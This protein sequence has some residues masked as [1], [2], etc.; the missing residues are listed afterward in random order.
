MGAQPVIHGFVATIE[1]R[2]AVAPINRLSLVVS[3]FLYILLI[4]SAQSLLILAMAYVMGVRIASGLA[5]IAMN[6]RPVWDSVHDGASREPAS[7]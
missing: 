1:R 6:S 5:G 2:Q 3:R 4:S 7:S